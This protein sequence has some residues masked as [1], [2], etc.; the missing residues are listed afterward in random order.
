M[1]V[2]LWTSSSRGLSIAL[3]LQRRGHRVSSVIVPKNRKQ[4]GLSIAAMTGATFCEINLRALGPAIHPRILQTIGESDIGIVAGFPRRLPVEAFAAPRL[5]TVNLHAG[6]L[7]GYRGGSPLSWQIVSGKKEIHLS[8]H[9][10]EQ[11]LDSGP[12]IVVRSFRLEEAENVAVAKE[13]AD[14]VFSA[15][16]GEFMESPEELIA[17]ARPQRQEDAV[18]WHQRNYDDAQIFWGRMC[19]KEVVDLVRATTPTYGGSFTFLGKDRVRILE[20]QRLR[21]GIRGVPGRVI[22][23]A[24][25]P[26]PVVLCSE[27]AVALSNYF[28]D[29]I[30]GRKTKFLRT[31]AHLGPA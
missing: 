23:I 17:T 16:V 27:G 18:Y 10:M 6:P 1:K 2:S 13:R 15:M 14:Q 4:A 12:V 3:E 26:H 31:G 28:Q 11:F 29:S 25:S 7:P 19:A 30:W 5:G 20:V 22:S 8:M 9:V 21:I 24:E